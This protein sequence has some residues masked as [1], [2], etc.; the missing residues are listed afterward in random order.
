LARAARRLPGLFIDL[1]ASSLRALE[2]ARVYSALV[3]AVTV[4]ALE[5]SCP[6]VELPADG[7]VWV[8]VGSQ[9]RRE[10]TPASVARGAIVCSDPPPPGWVEA[11]AHALER[12]GC[13]SQVTARTT[14]EWIAGDLSD[15]LVL[16]VLVERRP[17]WGTPR[18]PLPSA[19]NGVREPVLRALAHRALA[20]QP[21]TG[22]DAEAVLEADGTRHERLDIR[23]AAV[24]PIVELARWAGAAVGLVEGSTEDRL[25][26]A[27]QDGVL[28]Q[29]DARNL[30][31]CFETALE[32]RLA[33]HREKLA[34]G[35][36]PD[37]L[38][39]PAEM[40]SLARDHL[41]DVFR[42]VTAAQKEL[43]E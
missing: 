1:H 9:A 34:A 26:A 10:L 25:N 39:D 5:L 18:D 2:V 30:V 43:R 42:A 15:E 6:D 12:C 36:E 19:E 27:A 41:R 14:R 7:I 29:S 32:L 4:R 11:A 33:H 37:D 8:A 3:D 24:I 38:L 22:F 16:T 31:D 28:G 40:S 20:Y 23:R 21:P 17:L 35:S 13:S